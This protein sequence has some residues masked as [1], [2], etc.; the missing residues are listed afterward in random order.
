MSKQFNITEIYPNSP[1]VEVVCEIRFSAE[2]SIECRR[3]EFYNKIRDNYSNIL[4]P[5][6]DG[7]SAGALAPYRFENQSRNSGI[8][9]AI[10]RFSYYVKDYSGHKPFI[11]EFIRLTKILGETFTLNHL[12]RLGWRYIN[13]IPFTREDGIVPLQQFINFDLNLPGDVSRKYENFSFTFISR[14]AKGTITTKIESVAR[15]DEQQEA[16]LLDFDFSRVE[17]LSM[18]KIAAHVDEAHNQSRRLFENYITD[19]YRQYLRGET[20]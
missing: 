7:F 14:V 20:I 16:I 1:L 15:S 9:L 10:N 6:T 2:L 8:M 17:D 11:K 19:E 13:A 3:D 12:N 5:Q 4:V 18:S